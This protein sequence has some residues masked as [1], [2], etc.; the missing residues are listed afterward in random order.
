MIR[1]SVRAFFRGGGYSTP[2]FFSK[3]QVISSQIWEN[4]SH[5]AKITKIGTDMLW[6]IL[7]YFWRETTVQL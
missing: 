5:L 3:K 4:R 7:I 6:S 2:L 1:R